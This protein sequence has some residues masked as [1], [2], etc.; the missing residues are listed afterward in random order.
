MANRQATLKYLTTTKI[1]EKG[2]LTVP[3]QFRKDLGLGT[4]APF[5]VLRLETA[6]F[7]C[8]SNSALSVSANRW[9]LLSRV[10]VLRQKQSWRHYLKRESACLRAATRRP[11]SPGRRHADNNLAGNARSD[12]PTAN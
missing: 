6:W 5:A 8:Q 7:F 11:I 2:Q 12:Q 1:G 4:G 9:A 10:S 3:K